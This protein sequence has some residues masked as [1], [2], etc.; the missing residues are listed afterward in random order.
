MIYDEAS[1]MSA[2][3][4]DLL[5]LSRIESGELALQLDDVDLNALLSATA[6]RF[7]YQAETSDVALR[8]S[9]TGGVVRADERR[10]EQVCAN[11]LDNAIRFAPAGTEVLFTSR[12]EG[13]GAVLEVHNAGEPIPA[14]DLP[15]VF[16]RFYQ[17]DPARGRGHAGLGLAIVQELVQAHGGQV[18]VRSSAATGTTFTVRLPRSGPPETAPRQPNGAAEPVEEQRWAT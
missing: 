6:R 7:R 1:H 16:D 11:L 18:S 14:E 4:E 2:M 13:A 3:V 8:L 10:L 12:A 9:A 15:H 5:Y 17:G